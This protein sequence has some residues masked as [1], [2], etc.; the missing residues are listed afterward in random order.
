M[1]K[2]YLLRLLFFLL[3]DLLSFELRVRDSVEQRRRPF[4]FGALAVELHLELWLRREGATWHGKKAVCMQR[5]LESMQWRQK[6]R[7]GSRSQITDHRWEIG[8]ARGV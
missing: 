1:S 6:E 4:Q 8:H 7:G 3:V 2:A 5:T